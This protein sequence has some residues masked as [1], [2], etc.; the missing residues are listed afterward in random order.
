[1]VQSMVAIGAVG[2][3]VRASHVY[4]GHG[5][6]RTSLLYRRHSGGGRPYGGEGFLD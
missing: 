3:G 4:G 1:M 5:R 6:G 2:F